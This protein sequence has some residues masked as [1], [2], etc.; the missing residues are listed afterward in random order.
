MHFFFQITSA[1]SVPDFY[2]SGSKVGKRVRFRFLPVLKN[3]QY[4]VSVLVG[5][6]KNSIFGSGSGGSVLR[7]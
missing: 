7:F 6:A 2:G 5:S 3:F 1:G 4:S